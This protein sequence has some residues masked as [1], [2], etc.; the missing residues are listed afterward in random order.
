MPLNHIHH[1]LSEAC[2]SALFVQ[3]LRPKT[4]SRPG[5]PSALQ[6]HTQS[7]VRSCC[8]FLCQF[9][10]AHPLGCIP[11]APPAVEA[12]TSDPGD[13][14][15]PSLS[16]RWPCLP[17]SPGADRCRIILSSTNLAVALCRNSWLPS[18]CA[19]LHFHR[20]PSLVPC[21]P[22]ASPPSPALCS[23]T[24]FSRALCWPHSPP[25]H[26]LRSARPH[27]QRPTR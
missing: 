17:S 23:R 25:P 1:L 22:W 24:P 11:T 12:V 5:L 20:Q 21:L 7:A 6:P 3:V 10:P 16:S 13:R 15:G 9:I 2:F 27:F 18:T 14:R 4:L 8:T 19:K 26:R